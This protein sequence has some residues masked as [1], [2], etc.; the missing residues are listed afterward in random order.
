MQLVDEMLT[1]LIVTLP[2]DDTLLPFI[3]WGDSLSCYSLVFF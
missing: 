3:L 1:N 2:I